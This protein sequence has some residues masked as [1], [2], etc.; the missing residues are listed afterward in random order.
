M[1][2]CRVVRSS[3]PV[4]IFSF[5]LLD[6]LY[7]RLSRPYLREAPVGFG[8]ERLASAFMNHLG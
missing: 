5:G 3:G 8:L 2:T 6:G 1:N 4:G 7:V